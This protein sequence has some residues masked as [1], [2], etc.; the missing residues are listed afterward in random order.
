MKRR[1]SKKLHILLYLILMSTI[2]VMIYLQL[3]SEVMLSMLLLGFM[4][5]LCMV[6]FWASA[7]EHESEKPVNQ[8]RY[9]N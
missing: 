7:R 1:T 6:M 8:K 5:A 3:H 2:P 9:L 4:F